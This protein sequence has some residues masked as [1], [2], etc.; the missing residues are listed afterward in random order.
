MKTDPDIRIE[1]AWPNATQLL[2]LKAALLPPAEAVGHWKKLCGTHDMQELDHGT[3]QVLPKIYLNLQSLMPNDTNRII[4]GSSYKY[5]WA[6]NRML[7]HD[8]QLFLKLMEDNGLDVCLLKGSAFLGHYFPEYGM[9]PNGD[10]D[11]LVSVAELPRVI[12]LLEENDYALK[13]NQPG[14]DTYSLIRLFHS[15][16]FENSRKT[17]FDIHQYI[18]SFLVSSEFNAILWDNMTKVQLP[19]SQVNV[20]VLNPTLQ[21]LH[22]IIHG[23][24][25]S[26]DSSIRWILDATVLLQRHGDDVDWEKLKEVSRQFHLTLTMKHALNFLKAEMSCPIPDAVVDDF[27]KCEI[28]KQDQ[29]YYNLSSN[30]GMGYTLD[31]IKRSWAHYKNYSL[32]TKRR[33][34]PLGFYEFLKIHLNRKSG[35]SLVPYVGWK[36]ASKLAEK[37]SPSKSR[38]EK[39]SG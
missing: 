4:A 7:M 34:S 26:P 28:T 24:Q 25:F 14:I 35:W 18:S 30:I 8:T 11:I 16:S 19:N 36:I 9:R 13:F 33:V 27:N 29:T 21:L 20:Y 6:R 22:T 12:N 31:R 2:A 1:S 32:A 5:H 38:E 37:V 23:M 39:A 15:R 3:N 17:D 10:T